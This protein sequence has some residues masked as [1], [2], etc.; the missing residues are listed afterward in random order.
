MFQRHKAFFFR[1]RPQTSLIF[2]VYFDEKIKKNHKYLELTLSHKLKLPKEIRKSTS[3]LKIESVAL[4]ETFPMIYCTSRP[5]IKK[6]SFD[7]NKKETD[8]GSPF[9]VSKEKCFMALKHSRRKLSEEGRRNGF[10]FVCK[11]VDPA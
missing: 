11:E 5:D 1:H 6:Q 9:E 7:E 8:F 10:F 4:V 2:G 3:T